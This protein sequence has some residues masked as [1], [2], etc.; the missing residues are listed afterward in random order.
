MP[1]LPEVEIVK[2]FISQEILAKKITSVVVLNHRLRY[3]VPEE[4]GLIEGGRVLKLERRAKFIQIF[5]DNSQ[6][7]IIHLGMSGSLL[8]HRAN[9][10]P[11]KHDHVLFFLDANTVLVYN[12]PRRFGFI[13]CLEVDKIGEYKLFQ[14][15][16]IEPL[17][18]ELNLSVLQ[19]MLNNSKLGMKSFLMSNEIIVGI[20]NI[21][22]NEILFATRIHPLTMAADIC[23]ERVQKLL[24]NI[25]Q[26][27]L[28]AINLGG[29]SIQN[30]VSPYGDKGRF[31]NSFKVYGRS[32]APCDI[33]SGMIEKIIIQQR[34]SFFCPLCQ[35]R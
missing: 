11:Q 13:D 29:S 3:S 8:I 5:L 28:S 6:V 32:N 12:D 27:L 34:S 35:I 1:E 21:Y 10:E 23:Q 30:F 33:C 18:D 20:G 24:H 22:A 31:S 16:G 7:V 17:S 14:K 25:K 9:Y 15:L 4:I 19:L 2:N 26:V